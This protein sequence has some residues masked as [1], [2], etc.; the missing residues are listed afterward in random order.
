[1]GLT[2]A[3]RN[4]PGVELLPVS[5]LNLL[6]LAPGGHV[7][8]FVIWTESAFKKLD[9]L[10]GS[11]KTKSALKTGYSLPAPKMANTDLA[12]L[13]KSEEIRKVLRRP[14]R[15]VRRAKR[16]LNPLTNKRMMLKLN[17]YAQVQIR[18]A[19]ISEEKRKLKREAELAK[20]RGLPVPR[21]YEIA[22]KI[23]KER[24]EA[25]KKLR[26]KNK[27]AGKKPAKDPKKPAV[28][29]LSLRDKKAVKIAAKAAKIKKKV[30]DLSLLKK[31]INKNQLCRIKK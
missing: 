1:K 4:I 31:E 26:A 29:P 16:K 25:Q 9:A 10:Y 27:A 6:K 2:K 14:I 13:L 23:S 21:A 8:R 18:S 7:G 22:L 5:K 30:S 17:P 12:R 24:K 20:K 19:I 3:F 15:S 11:W 28:A